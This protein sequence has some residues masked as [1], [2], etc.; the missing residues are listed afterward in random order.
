MLPVEPSLGMSRCA[1]RRYVSTVLLYNG[2][3]R[4][5]KDSLLKCIHSSVKR[6]VVFNVHLI[7][8]DLANQN[9]ANDHGELCEFCFQLF[10]FEGHLHLLE[11][12][13]EFIHCVLLLKQSRLFNCFV[14]NGFKIMVSFEMKTFI[15]NSF[16]GVNMRSAR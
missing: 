12:S 15:Q 1:V 5:I 11:P 9:A 6:F 14:N 4:L 8:F 2:M 16:K 3:C 10:I 7:Y 13:F